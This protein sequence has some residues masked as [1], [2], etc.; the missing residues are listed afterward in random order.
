M[1]RDNRRYLKKHGIRYSGTALGRPL[2]NPERSRKESRRRKK[3]AGIRN[4]IEGVF[5][6]GKR[7]FGLG[8]VSYTHLTLP[9]N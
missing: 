4:E 9:T 2:I 1:A 6:V 3:E 7:R 5:G 8:P